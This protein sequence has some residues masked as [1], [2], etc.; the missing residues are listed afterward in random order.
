MQT[1]DTI[2]TNIKDRTEF[3]YP[4]LDANTIESAENTYNGKAGLKLNVI[5]RIIL[6]IKEGDLKLAFS[7]NIV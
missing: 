7:S 5:D 2:V 6:G 1:N 3:D 4:T